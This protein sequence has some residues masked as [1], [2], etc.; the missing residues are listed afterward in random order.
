M[1]SF[2]VAQLFC[3]ILEAPSLSTRF[4][5]SFPRLLFL[6]TFTGKDAT[7]LR[8]GGRDGHGFRAAWKEQEEDKTKDEE[9]WPYLALWLESSSPDA[10]SHYPRSPLRL[11]QL[12]YRCTPELNLTASF[13][14]PLRWVTYV[15]RMYIFVMLCRIV[16]SSSNQ[17]CRSSLSLLL[18]R[19]AVRPLIPSRLGTWMAVLIYSILQASLP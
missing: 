4:Q 8:A 11:F 6:P 5:A 2:V 10:K 18:G 12:D 15:G 16:L 19:S 7:G 14:C 17:C 3:R 13:L 1:S 9:E